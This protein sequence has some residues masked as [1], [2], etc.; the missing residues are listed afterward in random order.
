MKPLKIKNY[1]SIPHISKSK[2]G[3]G[4]H[5]IESGQERILLEKTRDKHD[6][7]FVFE[8]YDGTN[9]G[10]AK[11]SGKIVALTRSG[12]LAETSKYSQHHYFKDW[13]DDNKKILNEML[14]EGDR[15][16]GEWMSQAS[17]LVYS[18]K[19]DP[20]VFF[21]Y[22]NILNERMENEYLLWKTSTFQLNKARLLHVGG[23]ANFDDIIKKLNEKTGHIK[24]DELPEGMVFRVERKG[25]VDF[26]AKWVRS[27]FIPGKFLGDETKLTYNRISLLPPT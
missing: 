14:K 18:I 4:D 27:D 16:V 3:I 22:F 9:V 20:I 15:I 25:K 8:K 2:L 5:F 13:V 11:V 24:P 21:D 26:L 23:S 12:Y 19:G 1:G 6:E 7:V 10:I 17:G